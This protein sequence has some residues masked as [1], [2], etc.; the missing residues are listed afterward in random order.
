MAGRWY[1]RGS[2]SANV[3]V[4]VLVCVDASVLRGEEKNG[5]QLSVVA[6]AKGVRCQ[7]TCV[8]VW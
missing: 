7:L 4:Y 6:R 5:T 2:A 1:A 8:Y 3:C